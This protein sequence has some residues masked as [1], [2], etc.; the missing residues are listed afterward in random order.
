MR[1]S[2]IPAVVQVVLV[3]AALVLVV[4]SAVVS[5]GEDVSASPVAVIGEQELVRITAENGRTV[6]AVALIDTGASSSSLDTDLAEELGLDLDTAETVTVRSSLGEEQ[7][8]VVPVALQLGGRAVATDMNVNDRSE[9]EAPVLLGRDDLAGYQV[10][11]G[12]RLLT[13]PGEPVAPTALDTLLAGSP[14]FDAGSLLALLPLAALLVV[15]LRVVVGIQTLGTFAPVLLAFGYT[16]SGVLLGVVV[17]LVMIALGFGLQPLLRRWHLPRVARLGVLVALVALALLA[18]EALSGAAGTADAW[19][20]TLPVVVTA[21][22]VEKLWEVWDMDG[23]AAAATDAGL[24]LAVAVGV[25][26]VLL[27]PPVRMLAETV[28]LPLAVACG[29]WTWVAGTYKGLR[30]TEVFR[31]SAVAVRREEVTP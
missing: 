27:A 24:T 9:R 26:L 19:G 21:T 6:E 31:F 10:A 28:P 4:V 3:T 13:Q 11:V 1:T 8:P 2:R 25:T 20:A 12:Q 16:Q 7:R 30:L 5:R 15:L 14:V 23:A 22:A 17:T 29:V 18:L